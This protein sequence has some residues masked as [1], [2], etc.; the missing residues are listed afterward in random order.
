MLAQAHTGQQ[1]RD[2]FRKHS[3][4]ED[5]ELVTAVTKGDY[6]HLVDLLE[7]GGNPNA[8]DKTGKNLLH[9]AVLHNEERILK[10]LL[11]LG[12]EIFLCNEIAAS[13]LTV[14]FA[15]R[16][17]QGGIGA[18]Y[19]GVWGG[20]TVAVK[21]GQGMSMQKEI[22]TMQ[23]CT[24]PY[25]LSLLGITSAPQVQL[26]LEYMDGGNLRGYLDKKRDGVAVPVEYS[27]LEVAWVVA[28]ALA[29]LHHEGFVHRDLNSSNVLLSSTNY[30]KVA[31]FG[32]AQAIITRD[33]D[34]P[35][36]T[37]PEELDIHKYEVSADIYSFGIILTELA[38]LQVPYSHHHMSPLS[39]QGS[40]MAGSL[41]TSLSDAY[42]IWLRDLAIA[43]TAHEPKQRPTAREI[44]QKLQQHLK[45]QSMLQIVRY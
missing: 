31:N 24:S 5:A 11:V 12:A 33:E 16:M 25:L 8:A 18:I 13:E 39:L 43:C 23:A 6:D 17:S 15:C 27:I 4:P 40:V 34:T 22:R 42:P 44:V 3:K 38:S 9:F 10:R 35:L 19:K 7:R 41:R 29:D 32:S 14:D 30:I 28:N 20:R 26:V 36:W 21:T 2:H 45:V 1:V 37:A